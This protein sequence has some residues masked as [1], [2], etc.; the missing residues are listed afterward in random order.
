MDKQTI[1]DDRVVDDGFGN[2]WEKCDRPDCSLQVVRPGS[3]Q[4]DDEMVEGPNG[5]EWVSPC[6]WDGEA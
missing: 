1:D 4:C 5:V 6:R 3:A 2:E